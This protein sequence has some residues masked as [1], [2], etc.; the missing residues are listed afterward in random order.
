MDYF[1][2]TSGV[3]QGCPLSPVLFALALDPFLRNCTSKLPKDSLVRAYAD[4]MAVIVSDPYT[5]PHLRLWFHHLGKAAGLHINVDKCICVP[6]YKTDVHEINALLTSFAWQGTKVHFGCS[7]YLGILIGPEASAEIN[8]QIALEKYMKTCAFWLGQTFL[9]NFFLSFAFNAC[10]LP[11]LS[12]VAQFYTVPERSK[13][14]IQN[15]AYKFAHGPQYWL[16]M[17]SYFRS[18]HDIGMNLAR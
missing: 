5:L 18:G 11:I 8:L 15:W 12:F 7:K 2:C 14:T 9:G 16:D 1:L 4:D 10:C 13:A 6:L 3:C 17:D